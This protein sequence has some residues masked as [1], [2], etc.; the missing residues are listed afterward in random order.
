MDTM[1]FSLNNKSDGKQSILNDDLNFS[2][3][4][5]DDF[6][7][8]FLNDDTLIN[9][10]GILVVG[11]DDYILARNNHGGTGP[12]SYAFAR[13]YANLNNIGIIDRKKG[14]E[15][16]KECKNSCI[17]GKICYERIGDGN[18]GY[19]DI[20]IPSCVSYSMFN[21]FKLFYDKYNEEV[22]TC[23]KWKRKK[24]FGIDGFE[25]AN[26]RHSI[27]SVFINGLYSSDSLDIALE[28]VENNVV[29]NDY[30]VLKK[31]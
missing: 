25:E 31:S 22:K 7:T 26:R 5:W 29:V 27:F 4:T 30:K 9:N 14:L 18:Y 3:D 6:F 13:A 2:F 19:I 16:Y 20:T 11:D 21:Q 28:M 12:H 1:D 15:L 17:T 23:I 24:F 10:G 8:H